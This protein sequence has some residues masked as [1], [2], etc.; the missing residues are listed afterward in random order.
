M[1]VALVIVDYVSMDGNIISV[2]INSKENRPI[3]IDNISD[4]D[5]SYKIKENFDIG[6][7]RIYNFCSK[8]YNIYVHKSKI[9]INNIENCM[10]LNYFHKNV[11]FLP[12][13]TYT[14]GYHN[15]IFEKN[16]Y[17]SDFKINKYDSDIYLDTKNCA[18]VV[19]T[20]IK[21]VH[22]P[23]DLY[24]KASLINK[25]YCLEPKVSYKK[26]H[27]IITDTKFRP[28]YDGICENNSILKNIFE[29]IIL[30]PNIAGIGMDLKKLLEKYF[31]KKIQ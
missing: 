19:S 27:D 23:I 2:F 21:N 26:C 18:H 15:I 16:Y 17:L 1:Y 3:A 25:N 30:Q 28:M 22:S 12:K 10:E 20:T 6:N 11:C 31:T 7:I 9:K 14:V 5:F 8:D 24:V 13:Y 4:I 29:S